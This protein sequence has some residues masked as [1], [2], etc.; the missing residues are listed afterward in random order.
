[1]RLTTLKNP[2]TGE[3]RKR[4]R[5]NALPS[6]YSPSNDLATRSF[7]GT[8]REMFDLFKQG[9]RIVLGMLMIEPGYTPSWG[10]EYV[11]AYFD[12]AENFEAGPKTMAR[13]IEKML[14]AG[15][16]GEAAVSSIH[17]ETLRWLNTGKHVV[18]EAPCGAVYRVT[19]GELQRVLETLPEL[20]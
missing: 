10:T 9:R 5:L 13:I 20:G 4:I 16:E 15:S 1:M 6:R 17:G 14:V 19:V 3:Q 11:H 7:W 8:S 12:T 18:V 2:D